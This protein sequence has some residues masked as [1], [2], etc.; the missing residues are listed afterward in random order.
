MPI[1]WTILSLDTQQKLAK[2]F[3]LPVQL[4]K[5]KGLHEESNVSIQPNVE[6]LNE[7]SKLMRK[8]TKQK[9]AK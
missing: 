8:P 1:L 3:N 5:L 7:I 4:V 2:E 9:L 6:N